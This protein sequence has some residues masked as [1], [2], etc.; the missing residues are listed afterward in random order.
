MLLELL[1]TQLELVQ[2]I[3]KLLLLETE[4]AQR[5]ILAMGGDACYASLVPLHLVRFVDSLLP[6]VLPVRPGGRTSKAC[7]PLRRHGNGVFLGVGE[8]GCLFAALA[9]LDVRVAVAIGREAHGS[10]GH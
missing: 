2:A 5:G 1:V 8:C 10:C 3:A 4:I 9:A 6:C 7:T